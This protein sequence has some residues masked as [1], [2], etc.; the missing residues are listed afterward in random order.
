MAVE[1]ADDS[2]M[3]GRGRAE[4]IWSFERNG[5]GEALVAMIQNDES[6]DAAWALEGCE[7]Y[8]EQN[9]RFGCYTTGKSKLVSC[10]QMKNL[11]EKAVGGLQI[12]SKILMNELK[13]FVASGGSY[14]AKA[15]ETD[16]CVMAVCVVMKLLN[17]LSSYD[18]QARSMVYEMVNPNYDGDGPNDDTFGDDPVPIAFG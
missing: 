16:D 4:I 14:A 17:R 6:P 7:L 10:M 3:L 9:N 15:G 5:V 11:V 12:N 13:H 2:L 1:E 8:N 18:E